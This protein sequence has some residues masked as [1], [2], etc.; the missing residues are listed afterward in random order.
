M[1]GVKFKTEMKFGYTKVIQKVSN[2][3][4]TFRLT[5]VNNLLLETITIV[6]NNNWKKHKLPKSLVKNFVPWTDL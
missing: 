4:T 3:S 2:V 5:E 1:K 6:S